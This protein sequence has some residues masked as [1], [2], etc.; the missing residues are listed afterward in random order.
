MCSESWVPHTKQASETGMNSGREGNCVDD[1]WLDTGKDG[2][3]S[4]VVVGEW[5][6][7]WD[8]SRGT[9]VVGCGDDEV[10]FRIE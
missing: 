3:L 1:T 8:W 2:G 5:A 7:S 4:L 9:G 10:V 6:D